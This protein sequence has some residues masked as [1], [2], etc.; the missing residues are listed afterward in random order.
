MLR[1]TLCRGSTR[2]LFYADYVHYELDNDEGNCE[3]LARRGTG[4]IYEYIVG[5]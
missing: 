1:N 5:A 2:E 3:F 4:T